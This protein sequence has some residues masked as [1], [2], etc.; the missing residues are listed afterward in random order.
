[1]Y[2]AISYRAI[3]LVTVASVAAA[4]SSLGGDAGTGPTPSSGR[5]GA[6]GGRLDDVFSRAEANLEW[7]RGYCVETYSRIADLAGQLASATEENANVRRDAIILT[8]QARATVN[9]CDVFDNGK[10]PAQLENRYLRAD[11]Q[12]WAAQ[13][14][15]DRTHPGNQELS[16]NASSAANPVASPPDGFTPLQKYRDCTDIACPT[17]VALP[18]GNF[19]MGGTPVEQER[20]EIDDYR[21]AWESPRHEVA[22]NKPFGIADTEVTRA[23]FEAFAKETGYQIPAGCIEF[24]PPPDSTTATSSMWNANGTWTDPHIPQGPADPV[25]CVSRPDAESF[26]RWL[27]KKTGATYRLPTEAEWEYAAR[28]GTESPYYWG[29]NINEGCNYAAGYDQRTAAATGYGFPTQVGCDD[30]AAYTRAVGSYLPNA[31]GL[32]DVTGNAREWVSDAWE[33]NLISGP[34][35]EAPRTA[36]VHEFPVL[37]G[38]AWDY[39]PQNLR[40]AYRSAYYSNY[41]RSYMWGF[42]L[43]REF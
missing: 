4:C 21:A 29:W 5:P 7:P 19:Q 16:T 2:R 17:F 13:L 39:M 43:V 25:V 30:G 31:W 42:R 27:S 24:P 1:M 36:G 9:E 18:S 32:F 28:A 38:G 23:Q 11:M 26:A 10:R 41:I 3:A 20:L 40:I 37:R 8:H 22:I 12:I 33:P 35:T 34:T 15:F 14:E 6:V